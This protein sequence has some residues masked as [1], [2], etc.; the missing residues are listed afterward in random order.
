M[1]LFEHIAAFK[2]LAWRNATAPLVGLVALG[3]VPGAASE[4]PVQPA[5]S[6]G[7]YRIPYAD[8]TNVSVFDDAASHRPVGA[9]DLVGEP[10][11][12][13][14]HKIVAAAPGVV[15][16][17]RDSYGERQTGRAAAL[18][19]NNFV[20]LAHPNGEW[21]LYGHMRQGSTRG[22]ARLKVGETV[23][24]GRY[25][26]DEGEVGCAMLSHLHF[27]VA[28]PAAAGPIDA[29]GFVNDNLDRQRTR[30]P[31]FCGIDGAGVRKG[32]MYTAKPCPK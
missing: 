30:V 7:I 5:Q 10:R 15:M 28:V 6:T 2:R 31:R 9:V 11:D 16:A 4:P 20:W 18:C 22:A 13:R 32:A 26:G 24:A 23:K 21:T 3:A 8:G 27:E 19:R 25:L 1:M 14:T 29:Q 12:S 17:I